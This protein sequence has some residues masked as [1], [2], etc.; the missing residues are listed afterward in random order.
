MIRD[1][2][3]ILAEWDPLYQ[4]ALW[5]AFREDHTEVR[6]EYHNIEATLDANA[7][8]EKSTHGKRMGDYVRIASVPVAI[9]QK[10]ELDE[11]LKNGDDRHLSRWLNDPDNAKFR[12]SRGKF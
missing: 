9:A 6:V 1:G 12:T 7:E 5:I 2:D 10:A 11:A 3:F 4:R 8:F